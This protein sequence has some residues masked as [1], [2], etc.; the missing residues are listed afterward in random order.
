[1]ARSLMY[2]DL[3]VPCEKK[4][5]LL[6]DAAIVIG[7]SWIL[8]IS[9]QISF[10]VP[11]SVVPVTAQT[12]AVLMIGTMLGSNRGSFAVL[13]YIAQGAMGLPF[14]A[15][16]KAGAWVLF[17]PTGGYLLGFVAATMIVG[18]LAE[19]GWDRSVFKTAA[20]MTL[21]TLAIYTIGVFWLIVLTG[22]LQTALV[23]GLY[24][25]IAAEIFKVII[26]AIAF[27]AGWKLLNKAG[28]S[29]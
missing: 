21:G 8:A 7:A 9:A 15:M 19:K 11:F 27:P 10:Y 13:A 25:F 5:A 22:S 20:A 4:K 6:A 12:L 29:K 2:A 3:L 23:A 18:R 1:M 26:A 17:G 16:S 14:F 28:L 24:P